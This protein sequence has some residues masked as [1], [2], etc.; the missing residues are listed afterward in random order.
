M[1][2]NLL[3]AGLFL[4]AVWTCLT[5][6]GCGAGGVVI[7]GELTSG[8]S[9]FTVPEGDMYSIT[10]TG[11]GKTY[12]GSTEN[13]NKFTVK[14]V[15]PGK[16]KV[17]VIHYAKG[18]GKTKSGPPTPKNYPDDFDASKTNTTLKIDVTKLGK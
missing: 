11:G 1:K 9:A 18:D 10:L 16:Y 14:D 13:G 6:T 17:T 3:R 7:S 12:N 8:G 15:V 5:L 2:T 4:A